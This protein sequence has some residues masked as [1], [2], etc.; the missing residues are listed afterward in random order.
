MT[1]DKNETKVWKNSSFYKELNIK[2]IDWQNLIEINDK[3]QNII[4]I[5][6]ER[7]HYKKYIFDH[8]LQYKRKCKIHID[9]QGHVKYE[10]QE[11]NF[12]LNKFIGGINYENI[13]DIYTSTRID[14]LDKTGKYLKIEKTNI[15]GS[16]LKNK[17]K[18]EVDS[19]KLSNEKSSHG[20][21][22]G[23][24]IYNSNTKL[25]VKEFFY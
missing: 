24:L 19:K 23:S 16:S 21:Y 17:F 4:K 1:I 25:G 20:Y 11:F 22:V 3:N 8:E 15:F 6:K 12:V 2:N 9:K 10:T 7:E 5:T 18:V 13:F 14:D